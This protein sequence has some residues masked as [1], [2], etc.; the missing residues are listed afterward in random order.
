[1]PIFLGTNPQPINV[2]EEN[3]ILKNNSDIVVDDLCRVNSLDS[4]SSGSAYSGSASSSGGSAYGRVHVNDNDMLLE[5]YKDENLML[6]KRVEEL[7]LKLKKYTN[8]ENH[9]RY[10]AKNKDKIKE[11][12][13]SYLQKLKKENPE[14]IKEYSRTAYLNKKNK[15]LVEENEALRQMTILRI[16]E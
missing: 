11:T 2:V 13:A 3:I 15:K 5:Y 10:Y 16:E 1:M 14:K 4:A 12:G 6:T 7:E 8:G 9:K